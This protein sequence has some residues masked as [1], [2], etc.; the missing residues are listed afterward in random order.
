MWG[1]RV[2]VALVT[3]S[4]RGIGLAAAVELAR[5]GF[6][7][8]LAARTLHP[9]QGRDDGDF[10]PG[11]A[12]EGSLEEA[13]RAVE[14]HGVRAFPVRLDLLDA[15]TVD[16]CVPA[17]LAEFGRLDV[18]VNNATLHA[19]SNTRIAELT[20]QQVEDFAQA[21][22]VAPLLL[23][24]RALAAMAAQGGGRI[25]NVAS[26]AGLNDPPAPPGEG[27]WGVL[28][29]MAK[30]GQYRI[31]GLVRAEY[32]DSGITCFSLSPGFVKTPVI[33]RLPVFES[34]AEGVPASVPG[35][36]I[37]WLASAAEAVQYSREFIEVPE[38]A[39][40]HHLAGA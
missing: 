36:V 31:A 33:A 32:P 6:D 20:R 4:S 38:F 26:A 25:I 9:G 37:A 11:R 34:T 13:A 27:G 35:R 21:A 39:R 3:G 24:Q 2:A 16:Q 18:L 23:T 5:E 30:A 7:V 8:A 40:A 28:Y 1:Y 14:S 17:V 15:G 22:F 29:G 19:G 10:H 12:I